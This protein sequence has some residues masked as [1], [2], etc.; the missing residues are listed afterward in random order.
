[1]L[2]NV[3][4]VNVHFQFVWSKQAFAT[5]AEKKQHRNYQ[6]GMGGAAS[7]VN[8]TGEN[9]ND[10]LVTMTNAKE[11]AKEIRA[12]LSVYNGIKWYLTLLVTMFKF[13]REE[14]E[15][16]ISASFRG[17]TE[18]LLDKCDIDEQYNNQIDLIMRRLKDFIHEGSGWAV[19]QVS[20]LE[21]YLVTYKPISGSSYVITPKFIAN[22]N[23][24]INIQNKDN[25]YF[26]WS[27]L[28]ALHPPCL[29]ANRVNEYKPY[30]N[31]LNVTDLK[32]PLAIKD[33]KKFEKLN[34]SIS[35]NVLAF[36]GKTCI[37]PV[38]VTGEKSRQHH[39]NL[40]LISDNDKFHY[41]LIKNMS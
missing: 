7:T 21:L 17:E 3:L 8:I 38:Y 19:K 35:V 40:L 2:S 25:K 12:K 1:M 39:V 9:I 32:F 6:Q 22:K 37:Y 11:I 10:P 5:L 20:A 26:V 24:V 14:E 29:N 23:A 15:I 34:Q 28:A 16:T 36:D 33:V 31:E 30:D 4:F 13:N 18:M 27:I 41:V